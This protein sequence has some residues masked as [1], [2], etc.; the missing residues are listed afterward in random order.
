MPS[1]IKGYV[2]FVD[3]LNRRVGRLAMYLVFVMMGILLYSSY[4]KLTS[5]SPIWIVE[6][7]QFTLV[8]YFLLGSGYSMQLDAHVRMDLLYARW[9]P[10]RRALTDSI[11][12]LFLL[13]YLV[14]L[15]LGAL[16]S[17]GYAIEF[18][19]KNYSSWAPLM[20]PIKVIMTFGVVLLL[21]QAIATFFKDLAAIG[22]KTVEGEP[23]P[24]DDKP[25]GAP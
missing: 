25:Q 14:L 11:T 5:G 7:A 23:L 17:T 20:W 9:S 10:R 24:A 6:M 13:F 12:I 22:G 15:L 4:A 1:V 21:L 19:Q 18:N 16:S 3:G 2:R 8:A